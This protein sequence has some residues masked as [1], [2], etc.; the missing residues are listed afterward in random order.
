MIES[1]AG[2]FM[3]WAGLALALSAWLWAIGAAYRA[4][5][6]ASRIRRRINRLGL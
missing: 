4:I 5:V 6:S 1:Y 3:L 2:F